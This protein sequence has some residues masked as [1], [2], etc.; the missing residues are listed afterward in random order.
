[1]PAPSALVG[2]APA[3]CAGTRADAGGL[4]IVVHYAMRLVLQNEDA[5]KRYVEAVLA[6]A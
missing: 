5:V 4:G 3:A 1:M 6:L 2:G